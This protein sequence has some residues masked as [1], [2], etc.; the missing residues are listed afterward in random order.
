MA[1]PLILVVAVCGVFVVAM[2]GC[3]EQEKKV[4]NVTTGITN[5]GTKKI[6][7]KGKTESGK[8]FLAQQPSPLA[9]SGGG[10]VRSV[11]LPKLSKKPHSGGVSG[12]EQA[13]VAD[14]KSSNIKTTVPD[15]KKAKTAE[16]VTSHPLTGQE[17]NNASFLSR[18]EP[19]K[20]QD[21][22]EDDVVSVIPAPDEDFRAS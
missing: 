14:S 20:T 21:V 19:L 3:G 5:V 15:K 13:K 10:K 22:F 4:T 8:V 6:A 2:C 18:V 11:R 12:S 7:S 1:S 9:P 17:S 16:S